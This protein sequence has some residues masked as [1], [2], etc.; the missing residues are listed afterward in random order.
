[1]SGR[2]SA[3]GAGRDIRQDMVADPLTVSDEQS[4]VVQDL[5]LGD[6]RGK[7]LQ[8]QKR[9]APTPPARF[10]ALVLDQM[11]DAQRRAV[12]TPQLRD[13]EGGVDAHTVEHAVTDFDFHGQV[14]WRV[15]RQVNLRPTNNASGV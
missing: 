6:E 9:E 4:T 2:R 12:V 3:A 7:L 5:A 10:V 8:W 15:F 14:R 1:M 13:A 11:V